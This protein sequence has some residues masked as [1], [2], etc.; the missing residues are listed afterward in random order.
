[1]PLETPGLRRN[2]SP[3]GKNAKLWACVGGRSWQ[4]LES[5]GLYNAGTK[6]RRLIQV[7]E[8][9]FKANSLIYLCVFKAVTLG[10]DHP[11]GSA[12]LEISGG[13]ELSR[14]E[15]SNERARNHFPSPCPHS[16]V[17]NLVNT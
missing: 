12:S 6:R 15:L 11:L 5:A 16:F 9:F 10:I 7:T 3:V 1:M 13:S 8:G 4:V 14:A 2:L 17:L